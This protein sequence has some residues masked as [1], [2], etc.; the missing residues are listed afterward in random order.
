MTLA[1]N[2][3]VRIDVPLNKGTELFTR[4]NSKIVSFVPK[5]LD[6]LYDLSNR[7]I[8]LYFVLSR[9]PMLKVEKHSQL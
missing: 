1:L 7:W 3:D 8:V 9:E 4:W 2:N 5:K 6:W